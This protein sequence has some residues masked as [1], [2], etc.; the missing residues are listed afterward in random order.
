[1]YHLL[2]LVRENAELRLHVLFPRARVCERVREG[3]CVIVCESVKVCVRDSEQVIEC[4]RVPECVLL[5][6]R[7]YAELRFH[8][9][10]PRARACVRV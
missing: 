10:L 4:E 8:V 5:L 2:L 3:V 1:M 6:V 9:L 7:D